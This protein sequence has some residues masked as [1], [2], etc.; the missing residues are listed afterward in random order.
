MLIQVRRWLPQRAIVL[1]A[2]SSFAALELLESLRQ[3]PHPV[4]IVTRLRLDAALYDPA[5][6][7]RPKQMGR[8]LRAHLGGKTQRQW[9]SLA[10]LRTT[11]ALF[12]LFS[13]VVLWAHHLPSHLRYS[14]LQA[15]WYQS[16]I[17]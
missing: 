3:L 11:P 7:R 13:I 1:V 9:S 5:L 2:D 17:R 6:E 8:P 4:P 10:I 15:A 16:L 12:G 14:G